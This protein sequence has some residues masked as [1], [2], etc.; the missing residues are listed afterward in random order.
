MSPDKILRKFETTYRTWLARLEPLDDEAF[1][2]EPD[3]GGWSVGR[4]CHHI[5]SVSDMLLEN[6]DLCAKGD[7]VDKRFQFLPAMLSTVGS[8]PPA[9]IKVPDLPAELRHLSCPEPMT[10]AGG[11][12][13][14]EA[15][16]ERMRSLSAAVAAASP[17]V[18]REHP[19]GGWLN[20]RHWY[21]MTE[22]HLRHHLRQLRR[23]GS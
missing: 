18:R 2:R 4:I 21:H 8:L 20:A 1:E 17:R 6:A 23:T 13:R 5:G 12:A 3:D 10:K 7:G 14:L 15:V 11:I 16:A 22:M 19:A 9:R